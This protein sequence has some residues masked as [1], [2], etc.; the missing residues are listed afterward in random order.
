VFQRFAL[1][2]EKT[3]HL[4]VIRFS[5]MGDV[6]MVAVVLRALMAQHPSLKITVLSK[7]FLEPLFEEF[8]KV[9][10][11]AA[12]TQGS[13][14]GFR[15]IYRLYKE[16]KPLGFDGIADLHNVL[17]SRLLSLFFFGTKTFRIDKGRAE[18]K[19]L[20]RLKNKVFTPLK[21][22]HERTA[23]VFRKFELG[24]NLSQTPFPA[25]LTLPTALKTQIQ[26]K[27]G[28]KYIGIAPFAQHASKTYPLD[29]M[30]AVLLKLS[31]TP[32]VQLL[33]F[34]GGKK[35]VTVLNVL[36]EKIPNVQCMAGKLKLK[37]ELLLISHLNCML[38]MDS[39]NGHF[40]ALYGVPTV[41]LW[42]GTHPYAGFAPFQQTTENNLLPDLKKYPHI[43]YTVFGNKMLPGYE[44]VMQT[45]SPEKVASA[46][47]RACDHVA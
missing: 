36:E 6:A 42:G 10:F 23:D 1:M 5:A 46:V 2:K 11:Y 33:L 4:L 20:I 21:T 41:T 37:D 15:G 26:F 7:S 3:K 45:I 39:S 12:D 34:G 47:L 28:M 9:S 16:L 19:A 18:K 38:S 13:H 25:P 24:V 30:K 40:A 14:K 35:E 32:N 8:P 22:S 27:A 43:P 31:K 29:L 44:K 17:R